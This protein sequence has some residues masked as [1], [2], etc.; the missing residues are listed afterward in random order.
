MATKV[1]AVK[2]GRKPGIY[3]TWDECK[4]Q[5]DGFAGAVFKSFSGRTYAEAFM[6]GEA[7]D[8]R[9][10]HGGDK[11]PWES[12]D[13]IPENLPFAFVDG[14][15]NDSTG[16]YGYGGFINDGKEIFEFSGSGKEAEMKSMRNVAGEILGAQAAIE[17]AINL[18]LSNIYIYYDY[19]GIEKWATGEWKAN[20]KGTKRYADFCEMARTAINVHYI[21]VKG[22][23]GVAGNELA[24][25][26]AK[27]AVG[28]L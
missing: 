28:N 12:E 22:H 8:E 4:A 21:K 17:K 15:Y 20:K 24:D 6:T 7:N 16:T 5:T 13:Q 3:N 10:E 19:S 2:K 9:Q 23:S 26:L 1:Y 14:S 18:G 11:L 25:R 27:K